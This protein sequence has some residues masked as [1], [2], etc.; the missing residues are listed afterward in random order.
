MKHTN[1][2]HVE[3]LDPAITLEEW[4]RANSRPEASSVQIV[5]LHEPDA[6]LIA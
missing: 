3:I 5:R 1:K 4:R 2:R 6:H